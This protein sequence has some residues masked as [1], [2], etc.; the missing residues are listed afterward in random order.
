[1]RRA[2]KLPCFGWKEERKMEI[3][4]ELLLQQLNQLVKRV[5]IG[6]NEYFGQTTRL[7]VRLKE[8]TTPLTDA[9]LYA[10]DMIDA[11]L[12]EWTPDIPILSE[13]SVLVEF[14]ERHRWERYWLVDPLDGTRGFLEHCPE[15]TVN[16]ALIDHHR[17]VLGVVYAPVTKHLY[18]AG[19][20][21][22]AYKQIGDGAVATIH[23]APL[24][25]DDYRLTLGRHVREQMVERYANAP[26]AHILRV[27]SSLKMGWIAEG[28]ADLYPRFGDSGEWD[29]AAAQCVLEEAG[30]KVVDLAGHHLQYNTKASLLNPPFIAL[31]DSTKVERV[32]EVIQAIRR[33]S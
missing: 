18:Y 12:R 17:P 22:G 20:K 8:D 10:H 13:E 26:G 31:G 16:I 7:N 19:W 14:N 33:N 15:F 6:L 5:G 25:W 4:L 1:M 9:D 24:D 32:I 29:T 27:N 30:G 21:L 2:A 3:D 23:T 11:Q 28:K